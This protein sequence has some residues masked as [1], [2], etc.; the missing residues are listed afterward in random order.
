MEFW[1]P[2]LHRFV[3]WILSSLRNPW[4]DYQWI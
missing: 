4:R 3:V 2:N 1:N